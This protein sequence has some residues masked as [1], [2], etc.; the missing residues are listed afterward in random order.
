MADVL[1]IPQQDALP[2]EAA[3]TSTSSRPD[4]HTQRYDRQLRLWASSGQTALENARVLVVGGNGTATQ[5]LK[6]LVLP[7][8]GHFTLVSPVTS[9]SASD[10]GTNFFLSPTSL[11]APLAP[12]AV[13]HLLEL[14]SDVSGNALVASPS[15][16]TEEQ[17]GEHSLV[18]LVDVE[19]PSEVTRI[20]EAAWR[21][22]VPLLKVQSV[23]FFGTVRSQV[24]E[25]CIVETHP[26]S[27]VDLRVHAPFP[28]LLEYAHS[29]DYAKMDSAEHGHVP[30][31]VILVKALEEWKASHAGTSPTGTA[32]RRAFVDSVLA[33][34]RQSDEEN[35][36]EAVTLFRRAGT[37]ANVPPEV[38]ALFKDGEC[39]NVS[40]A[41]SNFWLLLHS[42]RSFVRSPS[43][44]SGLLPLSGALPDMKAHSSTYVALQN[45]YKQK[46]REDRDEVRRL[47]NELCGR[48]GVE[49]GRISDEE[50]ESFVKH[51]AWVRVVRG[52]R[53][54]E[55]E[56]E[57]ALKGKLGA[58]L[59]AASFQT[60]PDISLHIYASLRAA[61]AFHATHSR[62]PGILP[63]GGD[64]AS[65]LEKDAVELEG[66][67]R[68]LVK[69]WKGDEDW[70]M[71]GVEEEGVWEKLGEVCREIVRAPPTTTLPQ[72]S[73]LLGGIVAQEAIKLVT[74]QYVP[75]GT[76]LSSGGAKIGGETC[77]WDGVRSGTGIVDA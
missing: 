36:D 58:L 17:V 67:A 23:G 27:L 20:A 5:T 65:D 12:S 64:D 76:S 37:K 13:S 10:L 3:T 71:Y 51:A 21:K 56:K 44:P 40:A 31:V 68:G 25:L 33:Q 47:L 16:I 53:I 60:P 4:A 29:F 19:P 14:N 63:P 49:K 8:I 39:E 46:A 35:F 11:N 15:D 18:I 30:A 59:S 77:V 7:G 50:L 38:E 9:T 54:A 69:E 62:Y 24:E 48:L 41:S 6:N 55:E 42:L 32:D 73:A 28:A 57:C 2:L 66:L 34:K 52:R 22:R 26:E 1:P 70:S 61:D 72:T 74:K 45:L 75:L 43:N